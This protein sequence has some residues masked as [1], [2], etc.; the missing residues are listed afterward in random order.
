MYNEN[1]NTV[2]ELAE[3]CNDFGGESR[4]RPAS[5]DHTTASVTGNWCKV[6]PFC[7]KIR[8]I[9]IKVSSFV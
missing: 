8:E 7:Y 2:A 4:L 1:T 6:N 5:M 9:Y 3:V